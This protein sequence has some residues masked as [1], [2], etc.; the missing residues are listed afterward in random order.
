MEYLYRR[1]AYR[2][3]TKESG[4]DAYEGG[5]RGALVYSPPKSPIVQEQEECGES[6]EE[7]KRWFKQVTQNG[8]KKFGRDCWITCLECG[9]DLR[10]NPC[11]VS[12]RRK[13][14]MSSEKVLM[15]DIETLGQDGDSVILSIGACAGD[16]SGG[17]VDDFSVNVDVRS[18][19]SRSIN[20]STLWWWMQQEKAAIDALFMPEPK[21]FKRAIPEFIDFCNDVEFDGVWANGVSFDLK[22]LRNCIMAMGRKVPWGYQQEMCLRPIR[23]LGEKHGVVY[24][25]HYAQWVEEGGVSHSAVD[26]ALRQYDYLKKVMEKVNG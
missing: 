8:K 21:P 15:V 17:L 22:I 10:Y 13:V 3:N 26:D 16:L 11:W 2:N 19:N 23:K 6:E 18:Q 14:E 1:Q 4:M 7:R 9:Q 24:N 5:E 25:E 20:R 12:S